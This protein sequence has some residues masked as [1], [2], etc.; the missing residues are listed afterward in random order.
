VEPSA[1]LREL[2]EDGM[3]PVFSAIMHDEKGPC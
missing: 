2:L 1:L 3:A